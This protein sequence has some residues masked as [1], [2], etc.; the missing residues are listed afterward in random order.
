MPGPARPLSPEARAMMRGL[1]GFAAFEPDVEQPATTT[2]AV[3][4]A[5]AFVLTAAPAKLSDLVDTLAACDVDRRVLHRLAGMLDG[6]A[7]DGAEAVAVAR[8]FGSLYGAQ[9]TTEGESATVRPMH[10]RG[11]AA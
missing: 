11:R 9:I 7:R 10:A 1:D 3:L 5:L 8:Q 2:M 6:I 4:S